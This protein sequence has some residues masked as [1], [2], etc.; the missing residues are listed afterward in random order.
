MVLLICTSC[1]PRRPREMALLVFTEGFLFFLYMFKRIT[2]ALHPLTVEL[3][4]FIALENRNWFCS[5]SSAFIRLIIWCLSGS[6]LHWFIFKTEMQAHVCLCV[7]LHF[8]GRHFLT[9]PSVARCLSLLPVLQVLAVVCFILC[10][11]AHLLPFVTSPWNPGALLSL[12]FLASLLCRLFSLPLSAWLHSS[13][14]IVSGLPAHDAIFPTQFLCLVRT[15][16]TSVSHW[17]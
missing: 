7:F 10:L 5:I 8:P 11:L 16:F 17:V 3:M 15:S 4:S 1:S 14:H 13:A 12:P 6:C 9:S 2:K